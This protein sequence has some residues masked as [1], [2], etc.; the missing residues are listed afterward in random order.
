VR[1]VILKF[2]TTKNLGRLPQS[3]EFA[4]VMANTRLSTCLPA[5]VTEPLKE[6]VNLAISDLF[7]ESKGE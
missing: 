6:E 3:A 2:L 7:T 5:K 4:V 1:N